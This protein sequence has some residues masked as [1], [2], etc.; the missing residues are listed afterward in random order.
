MPSPLIN[1][2]KMKDPENVT[3]VFNSFFLSIAE[4]LKL[5][6]VR[7]EDPISFLK[8]FFPCKFYGIKIVP[9]S[10]AEIKSITLSLK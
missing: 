1:N 2:E 5:Q 6:Q 8:D 4:N 7:K 3:D 9:T 10:G